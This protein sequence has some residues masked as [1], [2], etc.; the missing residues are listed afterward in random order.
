MRKANENLGVTTTLLTASRKSGQTNVKTPL[1]KSRKAYPLIYYLIPSP[2]RELIFATDAS[3][4]GIGVVINLCFAYCKEKPIN[5]PCISTMIK[6]RNKTME[7]ISQPFT[8]I[9]R[10][11]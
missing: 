11:D 4:H 9:M 8:L 6:V 2:E 3:H 10:T 7:N 5:E 1:I